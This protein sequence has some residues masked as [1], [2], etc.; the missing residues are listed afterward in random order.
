MKTLLLTV[1]TSLLFISSAPKPQTVYDIKVQDII[2][3][4]VSLSKYKGKVLL[5]VN[6]A[7]K[8]GY[9]NQYEDLQALYEEY[10]DDDFVV[11]GFPANNFRNQEPGTNEEINRFCTGKFGVTFP[12][13]SK[14]SVKGED[15]HPLY[16]Y[17]TS[18]KENGKLNA[19]IQWNFQ[20]FLVGKNG[21]VIRYFKPEE[22][23]KDALI[24]KAIRKHVK[25]E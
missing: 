3:N 9:T 2:G 18:K 6:V 19:P 12:M 4:K 24:K 1:L 15:M 20:K 13:F 25:G 11:L 10:Q 17:L 8:C 14:I 21:K 7:S 5:I 23:V 16:R 22:R